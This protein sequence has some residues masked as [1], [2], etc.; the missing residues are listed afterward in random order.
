MAKCDVCGR[1]ML[2]ANGCSVSRVHC[3]GKVYRRQRY[4]EEGWGEPGERCP[5]CGAMYGLFHHWGCD[6]ERCPACGGQMLGCDCDDVYIEV[7]EK[8]P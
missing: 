7:P 8:E 1:E 6:I 4:G 2:K 3:N 5:D